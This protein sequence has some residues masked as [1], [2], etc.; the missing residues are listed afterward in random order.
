MYFPNISIQF[1]FTDLL[2]Q[3][4]TIDE[5]L[6]FFHD[7][8]RRLD[9]VETILENREGEELDDDDWES[10]IG[11]NPDLDVVL[12]TVRR[13]VICNIFRDVVIQRLTDWL[14]KSENKDGN[15]FNFK[16]PSAVVGVGRC[17]AWVLEWVDME[18][19]N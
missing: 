8:S 1:W 19:S 4:F 16:N 3:A 18:Y 5:A 11:K 2:L 17:R 6:E 13:Q 9:N 14:D 15:E 10:I 12:E 7:L